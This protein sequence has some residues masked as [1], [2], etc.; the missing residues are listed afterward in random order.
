[1]SRSMRAEELSSVLKHARLDAADFK[2]YVDIPQ[3][4]KSSAMNRGMSPSTPKR[5]RVELLPQDASFGD[6]SP[7]PGGSAI[8]PLSVGVD[9][10]EATDQ[11]GPLQTTPKR[12]RSLRSTAV[13]TSL[14][15]R[16]LTDLF[17]A[18]R[19]E[20]LNQME[21]EDSPHSRSRNPRRHSIVSRSVDFTRSSA[22]YTPPR[23][24]SQTARQRCNSPPP[25]PR[26]Q[27]LRERQDDRSVSP[28]L[29][30][31]LNF[32]DP[33]D[34]QP[35]PP[36]SFP[37]DY[38]AVMGIVGFVSSYLVTL[39]ITETPCTVNMNDLAEFI[40]TVSMTHKSRSSAIELIRSLVS[41]VPEWVTYP[42]DEDKDSLKFNRM[43]KSFD[44]LSRLREL[45]RRIQLNL[46]DRIV[47][48]D[49]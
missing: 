37:I 39:N 45:K 6:L 9:S 36:I 35:P 44:V 3:E 13:P 47:A 1:M 32:S 11:L 30:R 48:A 16:S 20:S 46:I 33:Q 17:S 28:P 42:D 8:T 22:A 27:P 12:R 4:N 41:A 31:R 34:P 2:I 7:I 15:S 24:R 21:D 43:M 26:K 19:E 14:G 18:V 38:G 10:H 25:A 49:E 5:S 40:S 23:T 29:P